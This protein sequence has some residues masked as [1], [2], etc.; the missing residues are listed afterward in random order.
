MLK[1]HDKLHAILARL[2]CLY[3][4][5]NVWSLQFSTFQSFLEIDDL[6][7]ENASASAAKWSKSHANT[8][9]LSEVIQLEVFTAPTQ[10]ERTILECLQ[11]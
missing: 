2:S 5:D 4:I 10:R 6:K 9:F 7:Y 1:P 3:A 11:V 8:S